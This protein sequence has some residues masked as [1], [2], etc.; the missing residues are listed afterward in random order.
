[1]AV[2]GKQKKIFDGRYEIIGIVGRGSRSVVYHA[3]DE[4]ADGDEVALKV[5]LNTKDYRVVRMTLRNEA[6]AMVSSRHPH[7]IRLNDFQFPAD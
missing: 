4:L 3:R 7:V 2:P 6:L 1:M 5:L